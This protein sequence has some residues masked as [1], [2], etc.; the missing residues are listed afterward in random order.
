[1]ESVLEPTAVLGRV[2]Q[3]TDDIEEFDNASRPA[4]GEDDGARMF[5]G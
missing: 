4:V 5:M 3:R 1:M 2:G